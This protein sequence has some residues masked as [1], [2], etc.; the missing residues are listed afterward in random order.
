[1]SYNISDA[2]ARAALDAWAARLNTGYV[3]VYTGARP[4]NTAT[5]ASGTLLAELR[6]GATAFGA[7]S[8]RT[9]TANAITEEDSTLASG[10]AGWFRLLQSDGTTAEMDGECGASGS[11]KELEFVSTSLAAGTPTR[12]TGLQIS[13]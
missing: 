9:I 8:G 3:R 6:F 4:A 12:I 10:T 2:V 13:M 1:M 7:A 11:G 5:A